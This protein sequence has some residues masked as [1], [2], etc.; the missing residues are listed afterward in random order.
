M[1]SKC[2]LSF[3]EFQINFFTTKWNPK[4]WNNALNPMFK[5]FEE[6]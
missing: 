5:I 2:L 6:Y 4:R 1:I 3:Y